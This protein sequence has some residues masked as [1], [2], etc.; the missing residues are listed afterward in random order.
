MS[1]YNCANKHTHTH[2]VHLCEVILSNLWP[3][4]HNMMQNQVDLCPFKVTHTQFS[5]RVLWDQPFSLDG[6]LSQPLTK[7][8]MDKGM[9]FLHSLPQ[10]DSRIGWMMSLHLFS[11]EVLSGEHRPSKHNLCNAYWFFLSERVKKS[12]CKVFILI[13]SHL[14]KRVQN[15]IWGF[16]WKLKKKKDFW[17]AKTPFLF[18]DIYGKE[19]IT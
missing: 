8:N 6:T 14:N 19:T 16:L 10:I 5:P 11:I 1:Y 3:L 15:L 4:Q 17:T 7:P 12:S 13:S 18:T 9:H 2:N